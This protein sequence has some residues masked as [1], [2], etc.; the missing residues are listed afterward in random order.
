M[1]NP[2]YPSR[3]DASITAHPQA[4]NNYLQALKTCSSYNSAITLTIK[5][6]SQKGRGYFFIHRADWAILSVKAFFSTLYALF[7]TII[8]AL[9]TLLTGLQVDSVKNRC[10]ISAIQIGFHAVIVFQGWRGAVI[11]VKSAEQIKR[12]VNF[13]LERWG[14]RYPEIHSQIDHLRINP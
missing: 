14:S 5:Q 11:P 3:V 9:A 8:Y 4:K 2:V 7:K 1:I 12:Q 10:A 13:G 6:Y